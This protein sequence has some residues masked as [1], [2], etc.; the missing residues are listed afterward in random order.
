MWNVDNY[1]AFVNDIFFKMGVHSPLKSD[2]FQLDKIE[3]GG[4]FKF[5]HE[6]LNSN[7]VY[8]C[9]IF[10]SDGIQIDI[11]CVGEAI[12]LHENFIRE[13]INK[14]ENIIKYIFVSPILIK[15]SCLYLTKIILFDYD[16]NV[17]TTLNCWSFF[18]RK[19]NKRIKLFRP[20][21]V[22]VC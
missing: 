10:T 11:D 15:Q 8:L 18:H 14:A 5:Y 20:I 21:C 6:P 13:N 16:G 3:N 1:I 22:N 17:Y 7:D 4:Y 12:C 2:Y 9:F 19:G